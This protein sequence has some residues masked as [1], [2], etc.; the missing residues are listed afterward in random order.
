VSEY[1]AGYKARMNGEPFDP[2]QSEDWQAGYRERIIDE[3]I[4]AW[5]SEKE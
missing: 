2:A 4:M 3:E 5:E 1:E